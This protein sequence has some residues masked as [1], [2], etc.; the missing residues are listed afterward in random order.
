MKSY[1]EIK[2]HSDPDF[3]AQVLMSALIS[4][5]HRALVSVG[6]GKIGLSFPGV[7]EER[8]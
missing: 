1:F 8:K 2:I 7:V 6:A 3:S 5:L 4:K